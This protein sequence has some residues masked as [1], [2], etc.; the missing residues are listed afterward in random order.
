MKRAPYQPCNTGELASLCNLE[1]LNLAF[2]PL[3]SRSLELP[4]VIFKVTTLVELNLDYTGIKVMDVEIGELRNLE[5]LQMEGNQMEYPF[6]NLYDRHPLLLMYF[7]NVQMVELDLSGINLTLLPPVVGRLTALKALDL[8]RNGIEQV[9]P[10]F[11]PYTPPLPHR[12]FKDERLA[13]S[14][15]IKDHRLVA[16]S[17]GRSSTRASGSTSLTARCPHRP[18]SSSTSV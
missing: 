16:I 14:A 13:L 15:A 2:N 1:R 8:S 7:H 12:G 11:A 10:Q 5:A 18:S 3:G 4:E 9:C 17:L 6:H